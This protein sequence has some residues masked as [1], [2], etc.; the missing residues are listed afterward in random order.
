MGVDEIS[1]MVPRKPVPKGSVNGYPIAR[2]KCEECKPGQRCG[3][4][5]CF[6]GT[7]VG[8]SIADGGGKELEAWE[9]LVRIHATS[10]RN[11]AGWRL[12]EKPG[13]I[14]VRFVFLRERPDGHLLSSGALSAEGLRNPLPITKPDE[15]KLARAVQ[16]ALTGSIVVDDSQVVSSHVAKAYTAGKPGL[17]VQIARISREPEWVLEMLRRHGLAAPVTQGALL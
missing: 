7:I 17:L 6:G 13:A 5:N 14:E 10:A 11:A 2:G 9:G 12:I 4:R 16:D 15:D 3:R 8:V 1:F